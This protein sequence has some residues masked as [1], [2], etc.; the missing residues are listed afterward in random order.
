[1]NIGELKELIADMNDETEIVRPG[2]DHSFP[3][4][5]LYKHTVIDEGAKNYTDDVRQFNPNQ[6]G[7]PVEVLVAE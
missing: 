3:S 5:R 1:M 4:A 6:P 7:S 2:P